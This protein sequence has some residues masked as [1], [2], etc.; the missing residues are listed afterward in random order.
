[1]L[2]SVSLKAQDIGQIIS[3]STADA[4]KY[5]QKYLEP[6]GRG[7]IM[8]MG[9]GWTNTARVHK[10]LGFDINI[11]AQLAIVP[12]D[13]QSFVFNNADYSTFKLTNGASSGTAQT[14]LGDTTHLGLSV[15]TTVQG[16]N[17]SYNFNTP[18]GIGMDMKKFLSVAVVPL[19]V[20][21][22]GIGLF[23]HTELKV[24]YFPKTDLGNSGTKVG[25]AG[26]AIQ[27]EFTNY[28]PFLGK[29]PLLH[30]SL[31]AGYNSVNVVYALTNSTV[32]GS[33]QRAELN[34]SAFSAQAIATLKLA[35]FEIT[36]SPG[37]VSG[38]SDASMK[39]TYTF[40]YKDNSSGATFSNTVVDPIALNYTNSG[41]TNTFG[42]RINLL[43]LKVFADYT[44]ANYNTAGA[45]VAFSFR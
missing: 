45:G 23:K 27:H 31:L 16:H 22:I 25:V 36:Y 34:I 14:F 38:K 44:F 43:F 26:A 8:N 2:A 12:T 17:V 40:N 1:M 30:I 18:G 20:A 21:Q 7:E 5:L 24:R 15:S 10:F 11:N 4:N 32:Q 35:L 29:A 41:F 13:K 39:G 33:D 42:L 9:R 37:F 19:P 6:F 28:L 3:G